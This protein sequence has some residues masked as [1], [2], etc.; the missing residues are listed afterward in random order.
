ME[1]GTAGYFHPLIKIHSNS[2]GVFELLKG[3]PVLKSSKMIQGRVLW[4]SLTCQ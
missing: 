2:L 4:S 1:D 3:K